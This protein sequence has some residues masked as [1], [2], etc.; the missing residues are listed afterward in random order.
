MSPRN[1]RSRILVA[2]P[3]YFPCCVGYG[4]R[5]IGL[6]TLFL[7]TIVSPLHAGLCVSSA[8]ADDES[9]SIRG[10]VVDEAGQPVGGAIVNLLAGKFMPSQQSLIEIIAENTTD[11]R[12]SFELKVSRH[13]LKTEHWFN[14]RIFARDADHR[15]GWN[16]ASELRW[17][18][19]P[20][21]SYSKVIHESTGPT[22]LDKPIRMLPTRNVTLKLSDHEGRP[23]SGV[24]IMPFIFQTGSFSTVRDSAD[25]YQDEFNLANAD[26]ESL[27]VSSDAQGICTLRDIPCNATCAANLDKDGVNFTLVF[28]SSES[29]DV[30]FDARGKL[31]GGIRCDTPDC[32]F[33]SLR[34]A[35][36]SNRD[37]DPTR[38]FR[39]SQSRTVDVNS[40][41]SFEFENLLLG[42][43]TINVELDRFGPYALADASKQVVSV[44]VGVE[45][46]PIAIDV[47]KRDLVSMSGRVID[48]ETKE[49]V[50]NVDLLFA[51][52][53]PEAGYRFPCGAGKT[54]QSGRYT[55]LFGKGKIDVRVQ[56]AP[57]PYI[58][59]SIDWNE[60]NG[61]QVD[62]AKDGQVAEDIFLIKG[63]TIAGRVE[64]GEGNPVSEAVVNILVPGGWDFEGKLPTTLRTSRDGRFRFA[65]IHPDDIVPIRAVFDGA[66]TD[67]AVLIDTAEKRGD[68]T[69]VIKPE[70]AFRVKGRIVDSRAGPIPNA[71]IQVLWT[72]VYSS[73][74]TRMHGMGVFGERMKSDERGQ[75]TSNA[76]WGGDKYNLKI[77]ADDYSGAETNYITG[78]SGKV[79]DFG[80]I[81]LTSV[82]GTISARVVDTSGNAVA[83]VSVIC[84]NGIARNSSVVTDAAGEVVLNGVPEGSCQLI[85]E[86]E[87][88][89]FGGARAEQGDP[90]VLIT[91][92]RHDEMPPQA[93]VLTA[94]SLAERKNLAK[95]LLLHLYELPAAQRAPA[96]RAILSY[97]ASVDPKT[98][99]QCA[100]APEHEES[101]NS[102]IFR[103]AMALLETDSDAAMELLSQVR[104]GT[105]NHEILQIAD[106]IRTSNPKLALGLA[107]L[108]AVRC[109]A[110]DGPM[111]LAELAGVGRLL[112]FLGET[113]EAKAYFD[114]AFIGAAKL[115][116]GA[117]TGYVK[118]L[119]AEKLAA[120]DLA[121]AKLLAD[122]IV[123]T[124]GGTNR[125][126]HLGNI[127]GIIAETN[128]DDAIE[129]ALPL[130]PRHLSKVAYGVAK[131]DPNRALELIETWKKDKTPRTKVATIAW[132]AQTQKNQNPQLVIEL[133]DKAFSLA[134]KNPNEFRSYSGGAPL[135]AA[136]VAMIASDAGYP[137][138][139]GVVLQVLSAG[140]TS[141]LRH[142]QI[143]HLQ[144]TCDVALFLTRVDRSASRALLQIVAERAEFVGQGG[145]DSVN[146]N[147]WL[148]AWCLTDAT[149]AK[150]LFANA[151]KAGID[152]AGSVDQ[153]VIVGVIGTLILSDNE[154]HSRLRMNRSFWQPGEE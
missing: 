152:K 13:I 38:S 147:D 54:D 72:R 109:R 117:T 91:V 150:A 141:D 135:V 60:S 52:I 16:Q 18:I 28:E 96:N 113:D 87:G 55:F 128:A 73:R 134:R 34:V 97:M 35:I 81:K 8:C 86:R 76:F 119:V 103:A 129:I 124:D 95:E 53:D 29:I 48:D 153:N 112:M 61:I 88:F 2:T 74:H 79:H 142:D 93:D 126:R 45:N 146:R 140:E 27:K 144:T 56:M 20:R 106:K 42:P 64:D 154:L 98:A 12:G 143:S 130:E 82:S 24:D 22:E 36:Y 77:S 40:D 25:P 15:I 7:I 57:E 43:N 49:G 68:V 101:R 111:Q 26:R 46:E 90:D 145:Y 63:A 59:V 85:A 58:P 62:V 50:A 78:E 67:G 5:V 123:D 114:E 110:T 14:P 80:D 125:D 149:V 44:V 39:L 131:S 151:I 108:L 4:C 137:D 105:R 122:Q 139:R 99:L 70:N 116:G 33:G 66:T 84:L 11:S 19:E 32:K 6:A 37:E 23:I 71:S 107:E 94:Y 75:F 69:L 10:Q 17:L 83:G 132:I 118:G 133:I 121:R 9:I 89:R 115:E 1:D 41:G 138:L 100:S 148:L 47:V 136:D 104:P 3:D 120:F 92:Y 51:V 102:V 65:Q 21:S 127:A 31:Q 30:K